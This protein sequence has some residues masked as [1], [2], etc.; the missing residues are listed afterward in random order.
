[1]SVFPLS[2]EKYREP[3]ELIFR[4]PGEDQLKRSCGWRSLLPEL[5]CDPRPSTSSISCSVVPSASKL[6]A[7]GGRVNWNRC[8]ELIDTIP[9]YGPPFTLPLA[10]IA[11]RVSIPTARPFAL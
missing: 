5:I 6:L 10:D 8:A 7:L 1:M 4:L 9:S 11:V 2:I 3:V